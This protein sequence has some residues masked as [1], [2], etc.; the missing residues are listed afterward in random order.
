M[1]DGIVADKRV[2]VAARMAARPLDT[3]AGEVTPSDRDFFAALSRPR[4]GFIL[5]VK[6]AS[7]SR[8]LIRADFDAAHIAAS[9]A[10][11]AD[12]ISVLTDG[13]HFQGSFEVLRQVRDHA[14]QP[15]L[16]K[17][18]VVDP[19]QL[20]E[21]RHHGADA[22]LLMCSVLDQ[23]TLERCL[24]AAR[25]IGIAALVEAHDAG[26]VDRAVA[27]GAAI[28]GINNRDLTSLR[29]DRDT[30]RRLAP[31]VPAD[32][33]LVCESGIRDHRD[34]VALRDQCDAF[35]VGTSLMER[36]DLDHAVR[37]LL[38][39]R[40]K[41]CG[42]TSRPAAEAAWRAG[43]R[44]GGLMLWPGSPRHVTVEAARAFVDVPLSWVGVFVDAGMD[45][46]ATAA[47]AL[48]LC[49]V[50]LHGD[51]DAA[52]L[53]AL[54]ARIALPIWKAARVGGGDLVAAGADRLLLDSWVPG[55]RG[56]SG[57]R[58]DWNVVPARPDRDA[59][60]LSGGI[61]PDNAAEADA[62]GVWALDLSS[63]VESSPGHKDPQ[64]IAKLFDALR[65]SGR[66][67]A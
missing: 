52:Y 42:L 3:F 63:G 59:L 33:L 10:P 58:F 19:Y 36:P 46:I 64:R 23:P 47:E 56:G 30:T 44:F 65:G 28:I 8:G 37:E 40:V 31:R 25:Q 1:L 67:S 22:I 39:G 45:E 54:R 17:D 61:T 26:E 2:E 16:C 60:I 7:P 15:V 41:I 38:F 34:V 13:R 57:T 51:E 14:P 43:A 24:R 55:V 27:A 50:Q 49:A 11:F 20:W 62:L 53:A 12:A 4:T 48:P 9:Y 66:K 35:L 21:A 5:E 29:V 6:R 18:F 32:R